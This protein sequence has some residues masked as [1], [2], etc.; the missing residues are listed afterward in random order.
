LE[1]TDFQRRDHLSPPR[2]P[3]APGIRPELARS[4]EPHHDHRSQETQEEFGN[5]AVDPKADARPLMFLL[6]VAS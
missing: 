5:H 6:A 4:A 1:S 3:G 2:Q